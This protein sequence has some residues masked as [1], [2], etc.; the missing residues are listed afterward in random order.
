MK[1]IFLFL[2][3]FWVLAGT[4]FLCA[5]TVS[6]TVR[7]SFEIEPVTVL[8]AT[9]ESG[10]SAVRLGPVSP[11]TEVPAKAL[12]VSVITNTRQRYRVY[13]QLGSEVTSGEGA[14]FPSEQLKFMVTSGAA[15][16]T[17]EVQNFVS[18]PEGE[19]PIFTSKTEGGTGSFQ[20]LYSLENQKLFSAGIYYGNISL[21]M[22]TE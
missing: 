15:G 4:S 17:S 13:H 8:R 16:G 7:V 19:V 5:Q 11:K 14:L 3:L 6:Q 20:I 12:N 9:S 22:R 2:T 21:D 10:V 18:I 1:K